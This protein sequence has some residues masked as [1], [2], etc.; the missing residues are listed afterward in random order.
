MSTH[1]HC[2]LEPG[3]RK[4]RQLGYRSSEGFF[5]RHNLLARDR[6]R[7]TMADLH[8]FLLELHSEQALEHFEHVEVR[9]SPR[10]FLLDG[11]DWS[12]ILAVCNETVMRLCSPRMRLILLI[13]RNSPAKFLIECE[14]FITDGLPEAFVGIDLAGNEAQY[15]DVGRFEN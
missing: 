3:E 4:W 13:N 14:D 9:L 12:D 6:P 2:H 7:V 10:R 8:S 1:L 11:S 15:P 5:D